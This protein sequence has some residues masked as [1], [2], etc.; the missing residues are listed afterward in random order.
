MHQ[1]PQRKHQAGVLAGI[2][3]QALRQ[4]QAHKIERGPWFMQR[5]WL[6]ET[7]EEYFVG[8]AMLPGKLEITLTG[9]REG[10]GAAESSEEFHAG[11]EAQ[12]TKNIVAIPVTLVK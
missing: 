4:T 5:G 6:G 9:L 2:A 1:G 3:S 10:S 7:V 11:L 8:V 12:C